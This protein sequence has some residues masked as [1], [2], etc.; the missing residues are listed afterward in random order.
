MWSVTEGMR[1]ICAIRKPP[2][3]WKSPVSSPGRLTS[4]VR[5][6]ISSIGTMPSTS[7]EPS[8]RFTTGASLL[9]SPGSAMS[10][11]SACRMSCKVTT[12]SKAPYSS[13][14]SAIGSP[15]FLKISS[16]RS[17]VSVLGT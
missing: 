12:P 10:P 5:S 6:L 13:T 14:T 4:P 9:G 3:V 2:S 11:T 1:F 16:A 17:A 7:H 15:D 8:S